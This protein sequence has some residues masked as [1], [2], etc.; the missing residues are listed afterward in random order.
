MLF[1]VS[2]KTKRLD[3]FN[4]HFVMSEL[5][6]FI[7]YDFRMKGLLI[8]FLAGLAMVSSD[9]LK[10]DPIVAINHFEF[11]EVKYGSMIYKIKVTPS[12]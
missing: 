5:L 9:F 10:C 3:V 1:V 8:V 2:R 7:L 4:K 11:K 6:T 12:R